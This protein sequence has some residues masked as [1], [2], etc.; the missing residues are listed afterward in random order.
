MRPEDSQRV[1][2]INAFRRYGYLQAQLD[3]L[4]LQA[5]KDVPEL[6]PEIYGLS[7][8]DA[9][10]GKELS[11]NDLAEQL[12]LIY[13]GP[14]AIEF[15]HINVRDLAFDNWEERQWLAQ[16]FENAVADELRNEER[17]KLAK[18]MLRCEIFIGIAHRGRLNLLSEM[19]QFPVVQMFRK[20]K[21]KPEF[22]D[23]VQGSGDVLSH[24]TSSFDHKSPEGTVHISMLPNPSHLEAVNPVAMG[25]ARARARSLGVGD[26]SKERSAR[27]GD[28]VLAVLVH[29]DGAFTGQGI[30]WESIS[31]SQA[32]HFRL[33]GTM[34]LV[35]NNQVAFTAEAHIGRSS[36]HCTDIAKAFEYPVIHV[37][38]DH[39]EEVV[40]ATRLAV[41]YRDK[42]RKD[43]FINMQCYRRWG[44]NELDDPSFT[45]PAMYRIIENRESVPRQ[46][47]DE[48][49]DEGLM[50]ED[51]VK[52][53]KEAHSAKMMESFRAIDITPPV[54]KHLQ[55]NWKGFVQAPAE[56]QKWDTGCEINLL[57]YV[58]AASVKVP[59]GFVSPENVHPH[60]QKTHCEAR[61]QK[62]V[63]GD[64][65]DWGTAEVALAFGSLLMEGNDVRISG[66]DVGRATFSFR[67]VADA[68]WLDFA[69]APRNRWYGSGT[70]Y[71]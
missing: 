53:E 24:L 55:G 57:K 56:V 7:P 61:I 47:A 2:L 48:L 68:V 63:A 46:Y 49:I 39:P 30:V 54:A 31:L 12:R 11:L 60:L 17:V 62:M 25:K 19:M 37:N 64:N 20:M 16:N 3:P 41:A 23:G 52:A 8:N 50:A 14:M 33:G 45:Q 5:E 38:G 65:L 35:T 21:G 22:P 32:P 51:D 34:H 71:M 69:A 43:V 6:N 66:Q 13:C 27:T 28:G 59:D 44:H 36:T 4:G 26:Y 10:P 67:Q 18:L 70:Q 1:H 58:G 15:M 42:F 40:K 29:G 9:L